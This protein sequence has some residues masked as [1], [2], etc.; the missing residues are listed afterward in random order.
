MAKSEKIFKISVDVI[1][2]PDMAAR[3]GF[4]SDALDDLVRSIKS[5][6]IIQPLL[7][8]KK[9][10]RFEVVAGH[11]RLAAAKAA[12]LATVPCIVIDVEASQADILKLHE[13]LYREDLNVVDESKFLERIGQM[14]GIGISD[15]AKMIS[16]SETYVRERLD[17]ADYSQELIDAL[18]TGKIQFSA[19]RWLAKITSPE[20]QSMYLDFAIRGGITARQAQS[21]FEAWKRDELP[22]VPTIEI[23][24]DLKTGE[25]REEKVID[26]VICGGKI[27]I[28]EA[29][30]YYA[31]PDCV[32]QIER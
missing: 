24:E 22:P 19:A 18:E 3:T 23:I 15:L 27:P 20:I 32:K 4:D 21:W 17:I 25:K 13:N 16:R 2:E 31:H 1:D 9:G 28:K 11:R 10:K 8:K 6:G 7:V 26:C 30:L 5:V 14:Y 12:G 29:R